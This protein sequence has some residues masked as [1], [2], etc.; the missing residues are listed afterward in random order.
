M[1]DKIQTNTKIRS[2]S[3]QHHFFAVCLKS[4]KYF[5]IAHVD[6]RNIMHVFNM[7]QF[8]SGMSTCPEEINDHISHFRSNFSVFDVEFHFLLSGPLDC[9]I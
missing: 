3:L 7:N 1:R 6:G 5:P 8:L 9:R 2:H 4:V